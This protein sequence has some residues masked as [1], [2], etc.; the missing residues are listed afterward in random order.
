M[1]GQR[2]TQAVRNENVMSARKAVVEIPLCAAYLGK[3]QASRASALP[4]VISAHSVRNFL[5]LLQEAGLWTSVCDRLS[6]N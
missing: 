4:R 6:G 1:M 5:S 3:L 2:W